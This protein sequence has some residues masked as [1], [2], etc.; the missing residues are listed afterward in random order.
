MST[1]MVI[2]DIELYS[3]ELC[4]FRIDDLLKTSSANFQ[5][6]GLNIITYKKDRNLNLLLHTLQNT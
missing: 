4:V 2:L 6:E 1:L 3:D 5:K